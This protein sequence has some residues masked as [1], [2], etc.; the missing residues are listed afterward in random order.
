MC[1]GFQGKLE[2]YVPLVEFSS[3]NSSQSTIEMAH[4][5]ALY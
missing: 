3:N 1:V 4:F 5:E 2:D